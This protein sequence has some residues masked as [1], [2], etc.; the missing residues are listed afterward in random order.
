MYH[1][2]LPDNWELTLSL[3]SHVTRIATPEETR[4][5]EQECYDAL[6]YYY[7]HFEQLNEEELNRLSTLIFWWGCKLMIPRV[8]PKRC[9][10]YKDINPE[11]RQWFEQLKTMY[12]QLPDD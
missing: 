4:A 7:D 9:P 5:A 8:V 12:E 10:V 1:L 11:F 6:V 2:Q 3:F